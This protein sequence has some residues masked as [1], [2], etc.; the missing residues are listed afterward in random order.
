MKYS[1]HDL[2]TVGVMATGLIVVGGSAAGMISIQDSVILLGTA[3]TL[4]GFLFKQ[5]CQVCPA[6]QYAK[7]RGYRE[8]EKDVA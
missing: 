3:T 2:V 1:T 4:G 7:D 6:M 5:V 8:Q